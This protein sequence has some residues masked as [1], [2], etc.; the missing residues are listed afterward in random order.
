[1]HGTTLNAGDVVQCML[2][3]A[4]RDPTY[5]AEPDRYD[6]Y[7]PNAGDHLSFGSGRHYCLGAALARAEVSVAVNALLD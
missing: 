5:F 3:A 4:N 1:M 2:G 7:R 6:I